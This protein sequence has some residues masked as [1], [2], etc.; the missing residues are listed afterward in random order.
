MTALFI[1]LVCI[2]MQCNVAL[3]MITLT[4]ICVCNLSAALQLAELRLALEHD[5]EHSLVELRQKLEEEKNREIEEVKK[6]QWV[7]MA[8][9]RLC[10]VLYTSLAIKEEVMS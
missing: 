5:K 8:Y 10:L 9:F 3:I 1:L 4:S 2:V 6:K 7:C